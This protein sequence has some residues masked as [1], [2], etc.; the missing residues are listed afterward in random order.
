ML[1]YNSKNIMNININLLLTTL[2][3]LLYP[4]LKG[5]SHRSDTHIRVN[6]HYSFALQGVLKLKSF[7]MKRAVFARITC[8]LDDKAIF[9]YPT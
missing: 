8:V 3:V 6:L 1:K 9:S 5:F 7:H 4:P 2:H